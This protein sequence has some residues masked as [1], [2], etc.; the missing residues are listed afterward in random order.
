MPEL[1]LKSIS[2]GSATKVLGALPLSCT[3]TNSRGRIRTCDHPRHRRWNPCLHPHPNFFTTL[4]GTCEKRFDSRPVSAATLSFGTTPPDPCRS[5]H[6]R[7]SAL[8]QGCPAL[9]RWVL[10]RSNSSLSLQA[11]LVFRAARARAPA[12]HLHCCQGTGIT[13][14][15]SNPGLGYRLAT[16][17]P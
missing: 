17:L 13:V 4:A 12:L 3:G 2:R 15:G 1:R 8:R 5:R 9:L 16:K 6:S 14:E 11:K 10:V 7:K